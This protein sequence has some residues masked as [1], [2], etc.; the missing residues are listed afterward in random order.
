MNI[1][2]DNEFVECEFCHDSIKDLKDI[3]LCKKRMGFLN[4]EVLAYERCTRILCKNCEYCSC[5]QDRIRHYKKKIDRFRDEPKYVL[6][7]Q[8]NDNVTTLHTDFSID[9]K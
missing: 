3:N 5:C 6:K 8:Y 1:I 7:Q 9:Y 4:R 2:K